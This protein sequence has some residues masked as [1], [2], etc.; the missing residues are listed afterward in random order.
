MKNETPTQP[1]IH[2][3]C[4]AHIDPVWIWDWPEG[5]TETLATFEAAANLL[6]EYPEFVFNHNESLLYEWTKRYRPDL[7]ERI[8]QHVRSGRWVI[9]GGWY[10]QPDVNLPCGE[11]I[12]RHILIGRRFFREEFGVEPR[13]A[14]NLDSFGHNGN[15]PQFLK[16]SGYDLYTHFR[17]NTNEKE[18]PGHLY[19]WRGVDGTEI[20]AFRPPDHWY[21]TYPGSLISSRMDSMRSFAERT[22]RPTTVFWGAGNHGGGAT[23]DDLET[24]RKAQADNPQIV[25]SS[26][27]RILEE[28][29]V[30]I[31][32]ELPAVEGEL[33]KC[34]TGSYTSIIGN[35][36]RNRRA[37]GFALAAER[38]ATLAWWFAGMEYPA[39]RIAEV[40]KDLLFCQFHDILPGSSIRDGAVSAAEI[41]GRSITNARDL[42]LHAQLE[43]MRAASDKAP[44]TIRIFNPHPIARRLPVVVDV[45][46]ATHPALVAGKYL[47]VYDPGGN[48]VSRQLLD[49]RRS[50]A[51]WRATV[52]FEASLPAMGLS[53]YSIRID[54]EQQNP[55]PSPADLTDDPGAFFAAAGRRLSDFSCRVASNEPW[56]SPREDAIAVSAEGYSAEVSTGTGMLR[57]LVEGDSRRELL[58]EGGLRLVVRQDSNNAWGGEQLAYGPVVGTFLPASRGDLAEISGQYEDGTPGSSVRII[59]SG[60]LALVV[61]SV[62]TWKRSVARVRTTF[63][64]GYPYVD[65]ELL[66][67]WSER[68]RALQLEL[69]T[70]L[71]GERYET[72]IPHAAISRSMGRGEEPSGRWVGIDD[73][74]LSLVLVNNGPGGVDVSGGT[75]RQTLVRSPVYCSGDDSVEPGFLGEHM[76]LGEF[77]YRFRLL[78]GP[79]IRVA[80][81]RQLAVDDLNLPFTYHA[82]VPLSA[83]GRD[84]VASGRD[85][86]TVS[87]MDGEGVVHLEAMKVSEDQTAMVV[88]LVERAG[89]SASIELR[90]NGALPA[91][92]SFGAYEMKSLRCQKAVAGGRPSAWV[93]CDLLERPFERTSSPHPE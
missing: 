64:R 13:V 19:T 52:L 18:L 56:F 57:S 44:L 84:G 5:A 28:I 14:Y 3:I 51:D 80:G 12:A 92:V 6:D 61:E 70:T 77:I 89:A 82:S 38:Y 20:A 76:D 54:Q 27:E 35:K 79:S 26:F 17:P 40:W 73:S 55:E 34:F 86:V 32:N 66:V 23:R 58:S 91:T 4:Q 39:D 16:L 65:I 22:G 78:F 37:E 50:T 93:E 69:A 25:H 41:V 15:L 90:A 46:L 67:N 72:E 45:Q 7:Y 2:L 47:G 29:V 49:Y 30:P 43:L 68:R 85:L 74:G 11:S 75:I 53:E 33:Q 71:G 1:R 62:M 36:L 31:V 87:P 10:L 60:P 63:Y 8:G 48:E 9:S 81:E 42:M 21:C 24:I 59:A 83:S 88:R